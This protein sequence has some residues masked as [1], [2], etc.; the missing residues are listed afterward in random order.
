MSQILSLIGREKELFAEDVSSHE[1]EL[2][3][4]ISTSSFKRKQ[5]G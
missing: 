1:T 5:Y 2:R 4:I 3:K